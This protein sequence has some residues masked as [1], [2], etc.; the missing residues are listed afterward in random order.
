MDSKIDDIGCLI[1]SAQNGDEQAMTR[2]I[3]IHKGLVF[4][5]IMRMTNDYHTS[6]DLTQE[7]F[8]KVFLNI[9]KVKSR[10]HFRP[11]ICTIARNIVRDYYRRTKSHATISFDQVKEFH[12][13]WDQSTRRRVVIQDALA[14]L[15]ERDRILLTLTYYQGLNLREVAEVMKMT[16]SNV[17][18]CIHRARKRLRRHL[19]G[20]EN[21]LM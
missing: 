6:E 11:W 4:T 12:G 13:Q 20:Y 17:K 10:E 9:K 18:V 2:L 7:T 5:I 1:R 19:E 3:T 15:V 14:K 16:E 21:E 8:I